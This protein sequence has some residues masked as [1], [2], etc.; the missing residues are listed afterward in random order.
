MRR[1]RVIIGLGLAV[2]GALAP[3]VGATTGTRPA[4]AEELPPASAPAAVIDRPAVV[5]VALSIPGRSEPAYYWLRRPAGHGPGQCGPLLI[6]LHGTD[7]SARQMIDFWAA[8]HARVPML[9][10]WRGRPECGAGRRWRA[11]QALENRA[12]YHVG[13]TLFIGMLFLVKWGVG[14]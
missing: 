2:G 4:P 12:H 6:A 5:K 9:I 1:V 14:S 13:F 8:R 7:D 10:P 11:A 3:A